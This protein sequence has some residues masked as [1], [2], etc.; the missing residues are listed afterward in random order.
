VADTLERSPMELQRM[1]RAYLQPSWCLVAV[2][3]TT[4]VVDIVQDG[5]QGSQ[6]IV[7][8][9]SPNRI[10]FLHNTLQS[11]YTT[12]MHILRP[13][14]VDRSAGPSIGEGTG[15]AECPSN[16]IQERG[17]KEEIHDHA[18][19]EAEQNEVEESEEGTKDDN[20]MAMVEIKKSGDES[21]D[22]ED[23]DTSEEEEDT[24]EDEETSEED[25]DGDGEEPSG[26]TL[27]S[28][29]THRAGGASTNAS[30][31]SYRPCRPSGPR[32]SL[33]EPAT[34]TEGQGQGQEQE[35]DG[36]EGGEA[37]ERGNRT[38][39]MN[40]EQ[41]FGAEDKEPRSSPGSNTVHLSQPPPE[42][43]DVDIGTREESAAEG[44]HNEHTQEETH[45][46]I[47]AVEPHLEVLGRTAATPGTDS[48][49]LSFRW[50][51]EGLVYTE[52]G[53]GYYY[54]VEGMRYRRSG[55]DGQYTYEQVTSVFEGTT[56]DDRVPSPALDAMV[57]KAINYVTADTPMR[58]PTSPEL[59]LL[60]ECGIPPHEG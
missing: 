13:V 37:Q 2:S 8:D 48:I 38:L 14:L 25:D 28:K 59:H 40:M 30:D 19:R 44:Q 24:L 6:V 52:R 5:F 3:I 34:T 60:Y 23:E 41:V 7:V 9:W 21:T 51:M 1:V 54:D 46:P 12:D 47:V 16:Y 55:E 35:H 31:G 18:T 4:N 45:V 15:S 50:A 10:R 56:D 57:S 58:S 53:D 43:M 22:S 36:T 49:Y 33:E 39:E 26:I 32:Q 17:S 27:H 29:S 11:V 20:I 42:H